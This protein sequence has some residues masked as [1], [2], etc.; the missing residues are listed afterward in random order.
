M[1]RGAAFTLI[2]LLIVIAIVGILTA[3]AVPNYQESA[4]KGR[5]AEATSSLM[6]AASR[7]EVV[8]SETNEYQNLN[9]A[10]PA[11]STDKH[12]TL[13]LT[14]KDL[15]GGTNNGYTLT[16]TPTFTD[17]YCGDFSLDQNGNRTC[18][19]SYCTDYLSRCW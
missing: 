4:R 8:F 9:D 2:E 5:R 3:I 16:A 12:Y 15:N 13:S 18:T 19:G 17:E 11:Q 6:Q 1:K 7:L 14:L 10:V